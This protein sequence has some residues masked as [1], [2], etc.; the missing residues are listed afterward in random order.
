MSDIS[1]P[2]DGRLIFSALG[3]HHAMQPYRKHYVAPTSGFAREQCERMARS[4]WLVRF[5]EPDRNGMQCFHV[6]R[7]GAAL[8]GQELP[9]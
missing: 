1:Q 2:E 8:I 5:G 9:K 6:T 3:L 7:E 4:G